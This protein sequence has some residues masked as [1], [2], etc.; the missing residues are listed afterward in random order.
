MFR[1]LIHRVGIGV[2]R[3]PFTT[4]FRLG[5]NPTVGAN[6]ATTTGS[7]IVRFLRAIT[8]EN[9]LSRF[10]IR[11][12]GN[13]LSFR[14]VSGFLGISIYLIKNLGIFAGFILLGEV[15]KLLKDPKDIVKNVRSLLNDPERNP[16]LNSV[17]REMLLD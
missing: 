17:V 4:P 9:Y 7:R 12:V 11:M 8:P 3:I 1:H 16:T 15:L 6:V 14:L 10:I 2:Q 13:R 5:L